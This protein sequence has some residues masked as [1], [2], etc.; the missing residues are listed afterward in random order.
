METGLFA[1][2]VCQEEAPPF[3]QDCKKCEDQ[4]E[5][6]RLLQE[7]RDKKKAATVV[8]DEKEQSQ[9][10]SAII[11]ATFAGTVTRDTCA[12]LGSDINLLPPDVL[13]VLISERADVNITV[14]NVPRQYGMA[15]Q[16]STEDKPIYVECDR[17]VTTTT[18]LHIRHGTSLSLRNVTWLVAKQPTA[19]PLLNRPV[20]EALG[21]DARK[22]LEAACDRYQ[23][24]VDVTELL[25][26][27]A[28]REGTVACLMSSGMY[29]STI[30]TEDSA[31]WNRRRK[32]AG[33][34]HRL[35]RE[36]SASV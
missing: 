20:L 18:E 22:A 3:Y 8:R 16:T 26:E 15:V 5:K 9:E 23:G 29:H 34:G 6:D 2:G 10:D 30:A 32:L 13:S 36:G 35:G 12:D 25:S 14:F 4:A 19:E 17:S 24:N 11:N 28:Y 31:G 1:P 7:H 27:P 33:S 21:L